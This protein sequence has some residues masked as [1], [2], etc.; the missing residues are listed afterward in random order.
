[1]SLWTP[2]TEGRKSQSHTHTHTHTHTGT[3]DLVSHPAGTCRNS[4][5]PQCIATAGGGIR[6]HTMSNY[7][8]ESIG[9]KGKAP[10]GDT[11]ALKGDAVLGLLAAKFLS[12]T[13]GALRSFRLNQH[14]HCPAHSSEILRNQVP[15]APSVRKTE[16][17]GT[18]ASPAAPSTQPAVWWVEASSGASS[19]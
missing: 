16:L 2:T 9:R 5:C 11:A 12:F 19:L 13:Q 4:P 3:L 7:F 14:H 1:M 15:G 6:C 8:H 10:H 17:C 18:G